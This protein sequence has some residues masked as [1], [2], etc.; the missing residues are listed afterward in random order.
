VNIHKEWPQGHGRTIIT[1]EIGAS[2]RWWTG[3]LLRVVTWLSYD[4]H[5]TVL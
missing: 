2:R 5:V 1:T 4:H 3:Y